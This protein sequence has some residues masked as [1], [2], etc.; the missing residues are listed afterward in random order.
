M[1]QVI[2]SIITCHNNKLLHVPIYSSQL[3]TSSTM[4]GWRL[5]SS[6]IYLHERNCNISRLF[7]GQSNSLKYFIEQ[8]GNA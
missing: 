4:I 1:Y 5:T 3:V 8:R 7:D 6:M 2:W